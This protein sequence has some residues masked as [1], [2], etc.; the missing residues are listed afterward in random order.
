[1]GVDNPLQ[2]KESQPNRLEIS[3]T[4][5][6]KAVV[7]SHVSNPLL[8]NITNHLSYLHLISDIPV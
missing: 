8:I 5:L 1:M 6:H 3:W 7:E 2:C 4:S